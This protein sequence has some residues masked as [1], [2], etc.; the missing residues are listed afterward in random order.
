MKRLLIL[1]SVIFGMC[2]AS[3]VLGVEKEKPDKGRNKNG[4]TLYDIP[5]RMLIDMPTAGTFPRGQYDI[6]VRLYPNGGAQ[7]STNIGLSNR[8]L[9]GLS[10]GAEHALSNRSPVWNP[11]IEFNIKFRLVDEMEL[12]PAI[13]IGFCSQGDGGWSRAYQRYQFKS[14]G[15]Y[16]VVS[17]SVYLY[18]WSSGWHAGL[19]Y[20]Y[21][22]RI[23][24]DNN[25][26]FYGGFDATFDYNLAFMIE[27][28]AA[29]NDDQG[30]KPASLAKDSSVTN[31]SGKGR[32]YLNMS[33]KW[34]FTDKLELEVM[35]KDLLV[36]RRES[37]TF[38]REARI[39]YIDHF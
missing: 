15:F 12:F 29:F 8:L 4:A 36:N 27:Y 3:T 23:D 7:A 14:R 11:D 9:I 32:G 30:D 28:D 33:L 39:T 2:V 13:S 22:N 6:G 20:S 24:K 37:S 19:N 31:F 18:K 26:D 35:F 10:Y 38:S 1:A 34:L 25:V 16:A 17:R 5:P 21:E